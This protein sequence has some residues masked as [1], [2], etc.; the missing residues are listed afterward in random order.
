MRTPSNLAYHELN[1]LQVRVVDLSSGSTVASGMVVWETKN[2][3]TIISGRGRRLTIPKHNK[4]FF[5]KLGGT[6]VAINGASIAFRPEE[7]T[8][9]V[10][11]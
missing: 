3:F 8:G 5:F 7:R 10:D 11:P 9:R 4:R 6:E 2:T 1:G